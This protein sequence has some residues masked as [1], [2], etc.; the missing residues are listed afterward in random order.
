MH[1]YELNTNIYSLLTTN[2]NTIRHRQTFLIGL[3]WLL[4]VVVGVMWWSGQITNYLSQ[5]YKLPWLLEIYIFQSKSTSDLT[6]GWND[7][8]PSKGFI[9]S[10]SETKISNETC[11]GAS[12]ARPGLGSLGTIW[13]INVWLGGR[14]GGLTVWS[15]H[16]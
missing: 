1:L 7:N 2:T 8:L 5:S 9:F 12:E 6:R 11:G 16:N 4:L 15:D 10:E 13:Q 14:D 3:T